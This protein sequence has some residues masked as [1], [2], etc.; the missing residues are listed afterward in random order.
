ME[1]SSAGNERRVKGG[2]IAEARLQRL[3]PSI[4][5]AAVDA[6]GFYLS[7]LTSD[8]CNFQTFVQFGARSGRIVHQPSHGN[9]GNQRTHRP[10]ASLVPNA[11]W[12]RADH[13]VRL[14]RRIRSGGSR[15]EEHT[16]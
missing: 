9:N 6:I 7:N 8:F 10:A 13:H 2:A 12:L 16:S 5:S 11:A 4:P 14:L 15:S 3:T 1:R